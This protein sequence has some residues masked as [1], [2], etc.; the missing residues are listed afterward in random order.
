MLSKAFSWT[1]NKK[2]QR[3]PVK[4]IDTCIISQHTKLR[5][6]NIVLLTSSGQSLGKP[7]QMKIFKE[8]FN[9]WCLART[10]SSQVRGKFVGKFQMLYFVPLVTWYDNPQQIR[11]GKESSK[12]GAYRALDKQLLRHLEDGRLKFVLASFKS[13]YHVY[14]RKRRFTRLDPVRK[15]D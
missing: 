14:W 1:L 13:I 7:T 3:K 12:V 4:G 5:C 11:Q 9:P 2:V 10:G 15:S 6:Y 8:I